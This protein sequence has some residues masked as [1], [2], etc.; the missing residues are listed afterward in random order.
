MLFHGIKRLEVMLNPHLCLLPRL[1]TGVI[2]RDKAAG[3]DVE[4]SPLSIAEVKN[5]WTYTSAAPLCLKDMD[6]GNFTVCA[7]SF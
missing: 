6:K 4:H 7:A 1:S 5:E 2:S 3:G